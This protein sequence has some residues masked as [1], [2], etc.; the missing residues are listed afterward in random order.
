LAQAL[1]EGPD[2][3]QF[4]LAYARTRGEREVGAAAGGYEKVADALLAE[5]DPKVTIGFARTYLLGEFNGIAQQGTPEEKKAAGV[6]YARVGRRLFKNRPLMPVATPPA[7][8]EVVVA[9][10]LAAVA[11]KL[12]DDPNLKA[13]A[14]VFALE[15]GRGQALDASETEA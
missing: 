12:S 8:S 15:A 10:E 3:T 9:A 14:G 11:A 13:L 5:G 7:D 6:L 2:R 1:P 4:W